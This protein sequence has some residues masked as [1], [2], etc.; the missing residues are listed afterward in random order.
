MSD[1]ELLQL[2]GEL[3][4]AALGSET[5]SGTTTGVIPGN[6][7][8]Q[9]NTLE[10]DRWYAL[11]AYYGRPLGNEVEN[12]SQVVSPD[13]RD[14][15]EWIMPQAMRIFVAKPPCVFDPEGPDDVDKAQQETEAVN[16]VF[17]RLNPGF[18]IIQ[19]Y[20]KDA[21]LLRNGYIRSRV[22]EEE[23]TEEENYSG[24][25]Q[26]M[27]TQLLSDKDDEEV[28]VIGQREYTIDVPPPLDAPPGAPAQEAQV[29]DVKLRITK[30]RKRIVVEAIPPE[31]LRIASGTRSSTN[32]DDCR[33]VCHLD[34]NKTRSD[35]I[36]E[37]YDADIVNNMQ[38]GKPSWLS[39]DELARDVVVD[40][41]S[42][43]DPAEFASQKIEFRSVTII[44]DFDGDGIAE[45]RQ[46]LIGG[47]KILENEPIEECPISAGVSKR[48]PH[49]HTGLSLFDELYDIQVIKSE[50]ARQG[51]NS[52][53]LSNNGRVAVDWKNCNLS[54][55]MTSRAGGVVR[56]N[57]PPGNVLMPLTQPSNIMDQVVPMMQYVDT[58]RAMR[59]GVGEHTMGLDADALQDVT[60]GGQ[61]AAMSAATLKIEMMVRL[62]A[63]GLKD[64]FLKIHA[65]LMRHQDEPMQLQL[66]K[67][68][69]Q[70]DPR[71][72]KKRTR[73]SVNV[74]LGSGNREEAR[75]N[76]M[77]LG[78]MMK[79]AA[80]LGLVGPQQGFNFAK[81]GVSLLGFE[82]PEDFVMDP[83]SPEFQQMQ[84]QKAQQPPDPRIAAAQ[85]NA[86]T[87]QMK[88]QTDLQI[89]QGDQQVDKMRVQAEMAHE[90]LQNREDR[91]VEM[92][93][94]DAKLFTDLAKILSTI[95]ASQLKGDES[96]DAGAVLRRDV[97]SLEGRA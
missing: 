5:A 31:K 79:E 25:N 47:D 42:I 90:A 85:I 21:L 10:V 1:E 91:H 30:K 58:W 35:L 92:S 72:W 70:V 41:M 17:M 63:E 27:L 24:L 89:A 55:L 81:M 84:A 11:N 18:F 34:D 60:K 26:V 6:S 59:T 50:L 22:V 29:F 38:S 9:L 64:V 28:E 67:Q 32:L 7:Q 39:M 75:Q 73:V 68:W 87:Q 13:I 77:L 95:V 16:H 71:Q 8:A 57:G 40:Q 78:N 82:H 20:V 4:R 94:T 76:M 14:T 65:L 52:L 62:L 97:Q 36:K 86:K 2:I 48:M 83:K 96:A 3:E 53:R 69:V 19:D 44:V 54:D 46:V 43:D 74:G 15:I 33:F 51:L 93:K 12:S 66:G 45:R 61:L 80:A 56:T 23:E 49:R 37:G 88:S